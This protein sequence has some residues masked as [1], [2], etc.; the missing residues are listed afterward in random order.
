MNCAAGTQFLR[1]S[2]FGTEVPNS[3]VAFVWHQET[4]RTICAEGR[5][6][7]T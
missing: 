5:F 4:I 7:K 6:R 1:E 3:L 2:Q